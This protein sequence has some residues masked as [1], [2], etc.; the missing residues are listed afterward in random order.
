METQKQKK[1]FGQWIKTSITIRMLMVGILILVLLIPLSYIKNLIQERAYRQEEVVSEINQKWGNEVLLY[2]PVLKIPYQIH[3]PKK[4]WDEKTKTYIKEDIITTKNA[5]FFPNTLDIN[6]NIESE[7]LGR[8]I[9]E[10]VVYTADMK[11][12]GSFTI[13]N[14]EIQDIKP[15]D[16]L[17]NKAT[18]LVNSTNSKGIKNNLEL[19]IN[20]DT[21]PLQ[22]RYTQN[23]TMNRFET[24][25]LKET[26]L[27]KENPIHFDIVLKV[28][29]SK[30]LRFI[31]V[32]RETNVSM[33]SNW[34]SPSFN[35]NYLPDTKTKE[36]TENGFKANWKVLQINRDFEQEFFGELPHIN[37]SAFG[38]KLLIPVDEY[39]KSERATKY[40]YL[41]I[42]LTFLVFFLIQ[43]VSKI[44]IHPFQYLMIGLALTMFYTLLISISEHSS[45]LNAYTV[46]GIAVILL[47]SVYSKT[48]LK[49]FKFMGLIGASLTALY[50]FI[51]VIIQLEN[52]ALLVGSIGLF[53]ILATIMMVSRKIDWSGY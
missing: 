9:Y 26:S 2:G 33:T 43:T 22:S 46:A 36:I 12:K 32:G 17:W 18:I 10:S 38:V 7:T 51:F 16:V 35:G 37:S 3:N 27:P 4:T 39:Q 23:S 28:N 42:A 8:N 15:E 45:F 40:G 21:Y 5:F 49:S 47:I 24:K 34:A 31:P 30:Q 1:S 44:N 41:V 52:Y 48:I 53:L 6:T 19:K 29:G 20:T 50:T 13:P 14:F 25:F 11:I